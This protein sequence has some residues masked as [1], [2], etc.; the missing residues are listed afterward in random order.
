[1]SSKTCTYLTDDGTK[2]K[3]AKDKERH[4]IKRLLRFEDYQSFLLESKMNYWES[5]K[6]DAYGLK[7]IQKYHCT[8]SEV[9]HQGFLQ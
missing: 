3:N 2:N 8:K 6:I 5:N 1:M 7:E 4:V 9:F